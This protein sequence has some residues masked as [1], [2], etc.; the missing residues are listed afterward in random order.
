M[1]FVDYDIISDKKVIDFKIEENNYLNISCGVIELE[2]E[3]NNYLDISCGP[4]CC[5]NV[6]FVDT[7]LTGIKG[8]IITN[9][10]RILKEGED[11]YYTE[12]LCTYN[13]STLSGKI[14]NIHVS[15][16]CNGGYPYSN[17][18]YVT[19]KQNYFKLEDKEEPNP[20]QSFKFNVNYNY[21]TKNLT[22]LMLSIIKDDFNSFSQ[23]LNREYLNTEYLNHKT[24]SGHNALMIAV[25]NRRTK[26]LK[27]FFQRMY[28]NKKLEEVLIETNNSGYTV[29]NLACYYKFSD[30]IEILLK[31]LEHIKNIDYGLYIKNKQG[32]TAITNADFTCL[33]LLIPVVNIKKMDGD[34]YKNI[35]KIIFD[36]LE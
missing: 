27:S 4:D 10:Q 1:S 36:K 8:E 25:I 17:C 20:D 23:I 18:F 3:D 26:I 24:E 11:D 14:F 34:D 15:N 30:C 19:L 28:N 32:E 13:V 29:M 2:L 6:K 9:I 5:N 16:E 12:G 22:N 31:G 7:D 33:K 35:L 21:E